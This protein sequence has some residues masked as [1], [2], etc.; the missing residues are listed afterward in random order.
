MKMVLSDMVGAG[1]ILII[2][3]TFLSSSATPLNPPEKGNTHYSWQKI[4]NFSLWR[5]LVLSAA[6]QD[7]GW[8]SKVAK[9]QGR[10]LHTP[11][12]FWRNLPNTW[13]LLLF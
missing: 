5:A 1:N 11:P 12:S 9:P 2:E 7:V 3:P 4:R 8:R 10:Y 13:L 6:P